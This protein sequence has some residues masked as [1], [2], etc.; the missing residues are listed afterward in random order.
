MDKIRN[1]NIMQ[2]SESMDKEM[3]LALWAQPLE[4]LKK[5]QFDQQRKWLWRCWMEV[6]YRAGCCQE[7]F[8]QMVKMQFWHMQCMRKRR[9]TH[10]PCEFLLAQRYGLMTTSWCVICIFR[11]LWW[12]EEGKKSILPRI[13][14]A[15]TVMK[16]TE[17]ANRKKYR[18][19]DENKSRKYKL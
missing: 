13:P 7:Q 17:T 2:N 4:R 11:E 15:G 12:S 1:R 16:H 8:C 5:I 14:T 3:E 10:L 18:D 6:P 9:A 19:M